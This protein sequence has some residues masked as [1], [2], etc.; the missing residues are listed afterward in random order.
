M[1][2]ERWRMLQERWRMLRERWRMLREHVAWEQSS[3]AGDGATVWDIAVR[4]GALWE[5]EGWCNTLPC[6]QQRKGNM[7]RSGS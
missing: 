6:V 4:E 1:L 7:L 2:Q 3:S 5:R